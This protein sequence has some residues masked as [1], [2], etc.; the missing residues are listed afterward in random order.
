MDRYLEYWE[1]YA[2]ENMMR[3]VELYRGV[4]W[5]Y[6]SYVRR[7]H[8]AFPPECFELAEK[9]LQRALAEAKEDSNAE[10]VDRVKFILTGL[11]HAKL[12]SRLTM[13]FD[14]EEEIPAERF[15]EGRE[16]LRRL[17][18]F[19]KENEHTFFSDLHHATSFWERNRI[20]LDSLMDSLDGG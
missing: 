3:F 6:S 4:G 11:E 2:F 18:K 5:R 8:I 9:L 17:V 7:A 12:A 10:F 20:D 14:G 13:A 19:R 16:A 1:K 15:E